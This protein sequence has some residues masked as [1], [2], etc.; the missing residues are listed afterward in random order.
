VYPGFPLFPSL[1]RHRGI[2]RS[3]APRIK[4]PED[5]AEG[6]DRL[7][8]AT[9]RTNFRARSRSHRSPLKNDSPCMINE[10]RISNETGTRRSSPSRGAAGKIENRGDKLFGRERGYREGRGVRHRRVA[11]RSSPPALSPPPLI[12]RYHPSGR[13]YALWDYFGAAAVQ[14]SLGESRGREVER[15][16]L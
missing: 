5:L 1:P 12:L 13:R 16:E 11:R 8:R 14:S 15:A 3:S 10:A 2:L 9:G 4:D 6:K 7:P